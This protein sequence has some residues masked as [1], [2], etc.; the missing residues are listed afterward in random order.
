MP[1]TLHPRRWLLGLLALLAAC[2][3]P[4][5]PLSASTPFEQDVL[6]TGQGLFT[7]WRA[8]AGRAA[9]GRS[10]A[11]G[12]INDL[13]DL[14][15]GEQQPLQ[16]ESEAAAQVKKIIARQ[17]DA[18]VPELKRVAAEAA[19]SRAT[20]YLISGSLMRS[21]AGTLAKPRGPLKPTEAKAP[22]PLVLTLLMLDLKSHQIVARWQGPL[23][24]LQGQLK[25]SAY[26][27]DSPVLMNGNK[28]G[29]A[30]QHNSQLLN[31][32]A[33]ATLNADTV[34]NAWAQA[35]LSQAQEAYAAANYAQAL[36]LFQAVAAR[37]GPLALRAYN[38]LYLSHLKLGQNDLARQDFKR[39]V[40]EGL[41]TR[42]LAMKFLF[43]P[44]QTSFWADPSVSGN[45][46]FWLQEISA[47]IAASPQCLEVAGHTSRSGEEAFN[48]KLSLARSEKVRGLMQALQPGLARRIS[49]SGKGWL[50]NIIGSGTDDA[51]DAIDRRV[52]FKLLDCR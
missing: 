49:T 7:Q 45:Y 36:A 32:P 39:V 33:G 15:Q 51:R 24:A 28:P 25:P 44:G 31:A 42:S 6:E 3:T 8:Q 20:D 46:E 48:Q 12:A 43:M 23:R 1:L 14:S 11:L 16:E 34:E 52:E 50:E 13:V 4:P 41:A 22:A 47:Q 35:L 9:S 19:N 26:F 29:I 10:V 18:Q 38:G 21:S 40:A 30:E 37:P 5:A 27:H 17:I 2:A